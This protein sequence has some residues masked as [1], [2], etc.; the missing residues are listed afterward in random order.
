MS[1]RRSV[2]RRLCVGFSVGM[3]QKKK[4]I[5][6]QRS[7]QGTCVFRLET[8]GSGH[9]RRTI[10]L[11]IEYRSNGTQTAGARVWNVPRSVLSIASQVERS[12]GPSSYCLR[13]RSE[14]N[15]R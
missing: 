1:W 5:V 12:I 8:A 9:I 15:C 11:F 10:Y 4:K 7:R 14:N 6:L 2:N 13:F 3:K